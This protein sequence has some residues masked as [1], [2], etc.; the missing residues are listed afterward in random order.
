MVVACLL[1]NRWFLVGRWALFVVRCRFLGVC[2]SLA[3][4]CCRVLCVVRCL[5]CVVCYTWFVGV[6]SVLF[7]CVLV[8]MLVLVGVCLFVC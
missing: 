3:V 8:D 2:V 1:V 5:S 4:V 6:L 7:C